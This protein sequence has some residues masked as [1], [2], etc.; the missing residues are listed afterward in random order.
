MSILIGTI[1]LT[2][3]GVGYVA[4]EGHARDIEI[5][6]EDLNRALD[7]DEVELVLLPRRRGPAPRGVGRD[8]PHHDTLSRGER[9]QGRIVRVVARAREEFVGLVRRDE[10]G[11]IVVP[12]SRRVYAT[13]RVPTEEAT[14]H[15]L[16]DN[17][18]VLVR[19]GEWRDP[20]KNPTAHIVR[21]LGEKGI[22][23]TE[24]EAL[25]A[26]S[27]FASGYPARALTEAREIKRTATI[28]AA[29]SASRRDF[30]DTLTFT[31]D[32]TDAKDFDDALS[33]RMLDSGLSEVGVHIADVS[34][35]VRPG[36]ALDREAASRATSV[37]LVDRTIP[38]LPPELS[39][40]LCS[41]NPSED[42]LAFSALFVIDRHA[43]VR[44]RWFGKSIIRSTRRFTYEEAERLIEN[45]AGSAQS[46]ANAAG[47]S[48][49]PYILALR[50]LNEL[51][52][53]LKS[54]RVEAGAIEFEEPE[55]RFTLDERGRPIAAAVKERL[56][57]HSLIEE[58]MLLAN[59]E[60]AEL[61]GRLEKSARGDFPFLYRVHD[62]PDPEKIAE[63]AVFLRAIGHELDVP[64]T[65]AV[66]ARDLNALFERLEGHAAEALVKKA[67][68]RAMAKALYSTANIGHFGLAFG[69]YTHFTSPIRRY[70]DLL[71][72]RVLAHYLADKKAG[73]GEFA[74]LHAHAL[75]AS[76]RERAALEAER[77]SVKYKQV[78]FLASRV[79]DEFDATITG[80][81]EW[82]IYVEED[83]CRAEGMIALRALADDYYVLDEKNYRLVGER[84]KRAF[85]LGERVRV[86]LTGADLDRRTLDFALVG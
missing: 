62:A 15:A 47:R 6:R 70:P 44:E 13:F 81:T 30:R 85:S 48:D 51:A 57:A 83:S 11:Y 21:V 36:T 3:R 19:L 7:G 5:L 17:L 25:L 69:Y 35:Y 24:M 42:K 8:K 12:D 75:H 53:K 39:E 28:R 52:K 4:L 63:L 22:H 76:A 18:K 67:A 37:Y 64:K 86:R 10:N 2:S 74:D 38:M 20:L 50:A 58:C 29:D 73:R 79:G 59:R 45:T 1:A 72:H 60:V 68:L 41:L 77:A 84:T 65:G 46:E 26:E 66:S 16:R 9:T 61:I 82:G 55:V 43:R 14:R 40:S 31:I 49:A 23:E 34:E 32:P 27:G 54:R 56:A 78:E 71:V 80:V 33:L